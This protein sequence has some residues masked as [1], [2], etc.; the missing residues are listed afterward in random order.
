M[1]ASVFT[2]EQLPTHS[3]LGLWRNECAACFPYLDVTQLW[4]HHLCGPPTSSSSPS[5]L[6]PSTLPPSPPFPPTPLNLVIRFKWNQFGRVVRPYGRRA[7]LYILKVLE[8]C[9]APSMLL[10]RQSLRSWKQN[11]CSLSQRSR[12]PPLMPLMSNTWE[13]RKVCLGDSLSVVPPGDKKNVTGRWAS[14]SLE[15]GYIF[16]LLWQPK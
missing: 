15:K 9:E 2:G 8:V 10:L 1:L 4:N 11:S 5:K 16:N 7:V 3:L 12:P 6:K 14:H 13:R